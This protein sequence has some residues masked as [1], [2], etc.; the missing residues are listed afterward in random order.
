M[1]V[2]VVSRLQ[3]YSESKVCTW[4][5]IKQQNGERVRAPKTKSGALATA[6]G[7][8]IILLHGQLGRDRH[9]A[10]QQLEWLSLY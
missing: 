1:W 8:L 7:P 5:S 6:L 3:H 9:R 2:R 4:L 10:G